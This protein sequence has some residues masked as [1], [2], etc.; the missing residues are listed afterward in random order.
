[1][2]SKTNIFRAF[3]DQKL[4]CG[5]GSAPNPAGGDTLAGGLRTHCPSPRTSPPLLAFNLGFWLFRPQTTLPNSKFLAMPTILAPTSMENV[6]FQTVRVPEI[7][8]DD[9]QH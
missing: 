3:H 1:M 2:H 8:L 9:I 7:L 5:H 6:K 4:I